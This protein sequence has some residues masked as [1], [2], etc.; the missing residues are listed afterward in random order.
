M[1]PAKANGARCGK[2]TGKRQPTCEIRTAVMEPKR[3]Y[4]SVTVRRGHLLRFINGF[5]RFAGDRDKLNIC[6]KT[7]KIPRMPNHTL[8]LNGLTMVE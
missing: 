2:R 4:R 8:F 3:F 1:P 5:A 7:V 6:G